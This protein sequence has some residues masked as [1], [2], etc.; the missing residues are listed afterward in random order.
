MQ[1]LT[2]L[3]FSF[4]MSASVMFSFALMPSGVHG[5]LRSHS[6]NSKSNKIQAYRKQKY[7]DIVYELRR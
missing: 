7:M 2:Y 1:C 3:A 6:L 5:G 4:I